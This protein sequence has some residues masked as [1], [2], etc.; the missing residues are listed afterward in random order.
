MVTSSGSGFNVCVSTTM[1][2]YKQC[3]MW[4]GPGW[5]RAQRQAHL[6]SLMVAFLVSASL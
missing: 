3:H 4:V 6:S 5:G 1:V 2:L